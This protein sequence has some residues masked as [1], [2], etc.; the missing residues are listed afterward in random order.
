MKK[1]LLS[2]LLSSFCATAAF[3][4]GTDL[5]FSEYLEGASNNKAIE[6]FNP[7]GAAVDLA[8]YKLYRYNNGSA[9]PSDS[10]FMRGMLAPG[11][12]Y[13]AG[14]PSA[15]AAILSVSDTLHTITFFNG[16]DA[17]SLVKISTATTLDV[18]GIIGNDPGVN[19]PVG[20]GATSEFTL[21]RKSTIASGTTDWAVGATEWDVY[22]QNTTSF[23]G[24]HTF[25][26]LPVKLVSFTGNIQQN[27]AVLHW[28]VEGQSGIDSYEVQKSS[29][30]T[31]FTT[32][33]I[34]PANDR[35]NFTYEFK[36]AAP[37]T[38][39]F[40]R[41]LIKENTK[42]TYSSVV[43]LNARRSSI[44]QLYPTVTRQLLTLQASDASVLLN[45]PLHII[46][47]NG[48]RVMTKQLSQLPMKLDVGRL[49]PGTYFLQYQGKERLEMMKFIKQ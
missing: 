27:A 33:T 4:Q 12:V 44:F 30:G 34:I 8:G 29:N 40:Y 19:W 32:I 6:V 31:D 23:L 26:V 36:D 20:T 11:D 45:Q 47:S 3:S 10:L 18:I 2:T 37:E 9:T 7:T 14:N 42:K 38:K 41:I 35:I 17:M 15:V 1:I 21:V 48:V 22:P 25:T 5:F 16:D 39:A 28:R 43:F 46:N 13:V 24:A 49:L